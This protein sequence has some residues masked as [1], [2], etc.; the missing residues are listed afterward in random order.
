M[1]TTCCQKEKHFYLLAVVSILGVTMAMGLPVKEEKEEDIYILQVSYTQWRTSKL[2]PGNSRGR[3][4][5]NYI[6]A[7]DLIKDPSP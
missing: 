4:Q 3:V 6:F 7:T 2:R 1:N 5:A